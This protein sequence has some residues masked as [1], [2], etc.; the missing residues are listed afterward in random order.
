MTHNAVNLCSCGELLATPR[1]NFQ[2]FFQKFGADL[3]TEDCALLKI[4]GNMR[5]AKFFPHPH[6]EVLAIKDVIC[7]NRMFLN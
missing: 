3:V 5:R 6:W 1:Q 7:A 2:L 4:L